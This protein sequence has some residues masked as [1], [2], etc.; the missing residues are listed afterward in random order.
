[1]VS[2]FES[3]YVAICCRQFLTNISFLAL[4]LEEYALQLLQPHQ[5]G[6]RANCAST[7]QNRHVLDKEL[8]DFCKQTAQLDDLHSNKQI[9]KCANYSREEL[10]QATRDIVR[11]VSNSNFSDDGQTSEDAC[12]GVPVMSHSNVHD[13][14]EG[15]E[16]E[17]QAID[18]ALRAVSQSHHQQYGSSSDSQFITPIPRRRKRSRENSEEPQS[19]RTRTSKYKESGSDSWSSPNASIDDSEAACATPS[20]TSIASALDIEQSTAQGVVGERRHDLVALSEAR[21]DLAAPLSLTATALSELAS[22]GDLHTSGWRRGRVAS[23]GRNSDSD[24]DRQELDALVA[25]LAEEF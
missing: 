8:D 24:R 1:M 25:E 16:E 10:F 23:S 20:A 11:H 17:R 15:R 13:N 4:A 12:D 18:N 2:R 21:D 14:S 5:Q 7:P 6:H 22:H 3:V 19:K 9:A